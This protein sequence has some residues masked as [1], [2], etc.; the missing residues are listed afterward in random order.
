MV[1]IYFGPDVILRVPNPSHTAAQ[2]AA[3]H[4]EAVCPFADAAP[5][6]LQQLPNVGVAGESLKGATRH[7]R[8]PIQFNS[9]CTAGGLIGSRGSH[10]LGDGRHVALRAGRVVNELEVG[11]LEPAAQ[12]VSQ[13][14]KCQG[15]GDK[16]QQSPNNT[17]LVAPFRLLPDAMCLGL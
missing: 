3:K 14:W 1:R 17:V 11:V 8:A 12:V 7:H 16:P 13:R 15:T 10:A 9:S 6:S 2:G 4:A 5:S